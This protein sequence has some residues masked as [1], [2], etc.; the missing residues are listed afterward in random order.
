MPFLSKLYQPGTAIRF[1]RGLHKVLSIVISFRINIF[2]VYFL[3]ALMMRIEDVVVKT[4][5]AGELHIA[6][7]CKMFMPFAGNCFGK[8]SFLLS[9]RFSSLP[10]FSSSS[11]TPSFLHSL[12]PCVPPSQLCLF[13]FKRPTYPPTHPVACSGVQIVKRHDSTVARTKKAR[14]K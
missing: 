12:S 5:L 2:V 7:A 10:S 1:A 9:V 11:L 6:S 14:K 8:K 4:V 13:T 3:V